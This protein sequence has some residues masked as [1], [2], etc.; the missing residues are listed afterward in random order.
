[1]SAGISSASGTCTD[2]AAIA[3]VTA[4]SASLPGY[5]I[6]RVTISSRATCANHQYELT[7]QDR[8]SH[9]ATARG[10]LDENGAASAD[11]S[12]PGVDAD[13][14]SAALVITG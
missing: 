3:Y 10:T 13:S 6:R 1:V 12:D 14:A 4:F 7:V 11:V 5:V 9:R 8:H 2:A